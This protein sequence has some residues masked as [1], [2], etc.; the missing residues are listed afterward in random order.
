MPPSFTPEDFVP[1]GARWTVHEIAQQPAV[2]SRVHSLVAEQTGPREMTADFVARCLATPS[3][4]IVLTGAGSSAFI[5][6][7]LAPARWRRLSDGFGLRDLP[8]ASGSGQIG[9]GSGTKQ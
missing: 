1:A 8:R 5:G 7:C 9:L 4:R 3:L 6:E 2:W